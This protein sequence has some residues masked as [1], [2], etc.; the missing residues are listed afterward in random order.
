MLINEKDETKSTNTSTRVRVFAYEH[1]FSYEQRVSS[2]QCET[3]IPLFGDERE[4]HA[5]LDAHDPR[6]VAGAL[7]PLAAVHVPARTSTGP[8]IVLQVVLAMHIVHMLIEH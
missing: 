8:R 1:Q 3:C 4:L 5:V 7:S 6:P 2:G